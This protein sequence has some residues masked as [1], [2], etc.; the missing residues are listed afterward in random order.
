[1][2]NKKKEALN[3]KKPKSQKKDWRNLER[4]RTFLLEGL[5]KTEGLIKMMVLWTMPVHKSSLG[6][7]NNKNATGWVHYNFLYGTA[8]RY[9]KELGHKTIS[10][11]LQN[12]E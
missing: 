3:L 9:A 12:F 8:V 6:R 4:L 11:K 10:E 1:M 7:W 2:I 5:K